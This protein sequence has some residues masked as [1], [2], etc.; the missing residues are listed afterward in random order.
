[1]ENILIIGAFDR[2]NYGDLLFPIILKEKL[3]Q[4]NPQ[5]N[6][7]FF[8]L[9]SSD[10]SE[11]GGLPTED[12]KAF[13]EACEN[14]SGRNHV[15]VA[16]GEA[17]GV[18][19]HSLLAALNKSYQKIHRYRFRL[20]RI[21]DLNAFGKMMLKGKTTLP[22]LFSKQDF[23]AVDSVIL[24]SLGGSGIKAEFFDTYTFAKQKLQEVDY[25]AV[26]DQVTVDNLKDNGL[27]ASLFPDCAILMSEFYPNKVLE[28]RVSPEVREYVAKHR[29]NYLYFQINRKNTLGKEAL[30]ARELDQIA[31]E[32]ELC[33]CPIG[34]AL[35]HDDH[36]ALAE[37]R[38][39]L[40]SESQYFDADS[41]WDIM[42]LIANARCYAGT[43][44]HGAITAM[45]YAVPHVGLKVEKLNAYLGTW[46]VDGNN[47][48]VDF[49]RL[50]HQFQ[51][52]TAIDPVVYEQA[53]LYQI[54]KINQAFEA[55][56]TIIYK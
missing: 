31:Q 55:I 42:Y 49:D 51:Q 41:I 34:K 9:V 54:A 27:E 47:F 25:L 12:I 22:F 53:R 11:V 30:I 18:T 19:W 36:I 50:S 20:S 3:A 40:N 7:R 28:Q 23:P 4:K 16:G 26:R 32:T 10:L 43:S 33:L 38:G 15:I 17:L 1:M 5:L 39:L 14:K 24:N 56:E 44:L 13:Y 8:G 46:G 45:S 29:G 35:D 6:F 37:V 21:F 2:Y 52:A 48:G